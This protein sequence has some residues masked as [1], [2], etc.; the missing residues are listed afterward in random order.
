VRKNLLKSQQKK[1]YFNLFDSKQR[2]NIKAKAEE[3]NKLTSKRFF[4][5]KIFES[6]K[7]APKGIY[8]IQA[9]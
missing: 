2:K 7:M 8:D 1:N 6:L 3:N 5:E 4:Y 9:Y